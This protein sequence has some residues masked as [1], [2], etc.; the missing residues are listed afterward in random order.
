[1]IKD[2]MQDDR[3]LSAACIPPSALARVE[4]VKGHEP[5]EKT[6]A[7]HEFLLASV[8]SLHHQHH[9]TVVLAK[10]KEESF[11]T[12]ILLGLLLID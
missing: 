2:I 3:E 8:F 9:T 10:K 1:M 7:N 4:G 11:F 5:F 12:E 6:T